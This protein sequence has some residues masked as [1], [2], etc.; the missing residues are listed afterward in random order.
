MYIYVSCSHSAMSSLEYC[1]LEFRIQ[2][3]FLLVFNSQWITGFVH[4]SNNDK[5]ISNSSYPSIYGACV[6]L[7]VLCMEHYNSTQPYLVMHYVAQSALLL[8]PTW[9]RACVHTHACTHTHTHI[10]T[11]HTHIHTHTHT[12]RKTRQTQT[13][14]Q[15]PP[16]PPPHSLPVS[17]SPPQIIT[18][19]YISSNK[20]KIKA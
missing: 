20:I 18:S 9:T 2:I 3:G 12:H 6:G 11:T 10:C 4:V 19:E 1:L 15:S 14:T 8:P 7:K 13:H 5:Y 16:T 17:P